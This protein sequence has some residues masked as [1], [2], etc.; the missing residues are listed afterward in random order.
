[1][2]NFVQFLLLHE[3]LFLSWYAKHK[4]NR[5]DLYSINL[6]MIYMSWKDWLLL[7]QGMFQK[8]GKE[9]YLDSR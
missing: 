6:R 2:L 1:M 5:F 9:E 8:E 7:D 4:Y 3:I